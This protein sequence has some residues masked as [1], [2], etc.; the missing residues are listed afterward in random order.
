[1]VLISFIS[2]R[3]QNW[4][5]T[6]H[7]FFT[8]LTR[9]MPWRGMLVNQNSERN[10]IINMNTRTPGHVLVCVLLVTWMGDLP[11]KAF[12]PSLGM[13]FLC[14]MSCMLIKLAHQNI[15]PSIQYTVGIILI[16]SICFSSHFLF[17]EQ[18]LLSIFMKMNEWNRKIGYRWDGCQYLTTTGH[19]APRRGM[20]AVLPVMPL[21]FMNAGEIF[22]PTG[23]L[24]LKNMGLSFTPME[25]PGNLCIL[26]QDCLVI[27]RYI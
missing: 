14:A 23:T 25:S 20:K 15:A 27:S 9:D 12:K 22:F 13:Q 1:M 11:F 18:V 26:L 8:G 3:W 21:C 16:N 19:C 6:S 4:T 7:A 5:V 2:C 24:S 10:Y 17:L